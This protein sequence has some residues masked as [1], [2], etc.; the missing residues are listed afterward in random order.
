M[1]NGSNGSALKTNSA[2]AA[3][4]RGRIPLP[5]SA[6]W[7]TQPLTREEV[8][9][10]GTEARLCVVVLIILLPRPLEEEYMRRLCII[11]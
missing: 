7:N 3:C 4:Y 10:G 6:T 5:F 1:C 8:R 2:S 9:V 11:T